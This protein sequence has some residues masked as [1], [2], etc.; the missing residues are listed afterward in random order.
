MWLLNSDL[1][2]S[3][4][5]E[6]L[7]VWTSLPFWGTGKLY[8]DIRN[9]KEMYDSLASVNCIELLKTTMGIDVTETLTTFS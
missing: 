3:Q 2:A 8:R 1:F 6:G 4:E 7:T 5:S 9:V